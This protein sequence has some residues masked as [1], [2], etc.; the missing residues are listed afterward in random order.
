MSLLVR[1]C[2]TERMNVSRIAVRVLIVAGGLVWAVMLFAAGTAQ[3]YTDL[4]YTLEDVTAG[5]ISAAL[6]LVLTVAVFV[7]AMFY[8]KLAAV[9]LLAAA[10]A[11]V[12]FGL[13]TGWDPLVWVS[14]LVALVLPMVVSA[15]LLLLAASTQ[16]VCE[17]E[18]K[19]SA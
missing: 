16:Q 4:A 10:A 15:A 5:G 3:S 9:V 13:L 19:L 11:T 7:L 17:L 14:V 12:V 2:S 1:T 18:G 8:E 6:P